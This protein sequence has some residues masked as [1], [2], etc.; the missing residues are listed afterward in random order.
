[1]VKDARAEG[2]ELRFVSC[3]SRKARFFEQRSGCSK[4]IA[5]IPNRL[6]VSNQSVG[7]HSMVATC[8]ARQKTHQSRCLSS[9]RR[10]K[11]K[12][13]DFQA[14]GPRF[15]RNGDLF[16]LSK[17]SRSIHRANNSLKAHRRRHGRRLL[18]P[19][20]RA[21]WQS[22][23]DK[24]PLLDIKNPTCSYRVVPDNQIEASN[25]SSMKS[26]TISICTLLPFKLSVERNYNAW[27][28]FGSLQPKK[29]RFRSA[30]S[31]DH[32]EESNKCD[33]LVKHAKLVTFD[34]G[35]AA[36]QSLCQQL[37]QRVLDF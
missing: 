26:S 30:T 28:I 2:Y 32:V 29:A 11:S 6:Q 18:F 3:E 24:T 23:N 12:K 25:V 13:F 19:S 15:H 17:T 1:M 34:V 21:I 9:F 22:K 10:F 31:Q 16:R 36:I 20:Q 14:K 37:F 27:Q 4:S 8:E 5:P 7:S 35:V 33:Q